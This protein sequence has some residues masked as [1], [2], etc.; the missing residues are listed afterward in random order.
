MRQAAD[1]PVCV[2]SRIALPIRTFLPEKYV[3]NRWSL[4]LLLCWLAL[5]STAWPSEEKDKG[6]TA[7]PRGKSDRPK[8]NGRHPTVTV[9]TEAPGL[10]PEEVEQLVTVPLETML[11]GTAGLRHVRSAS[12]AGRSVI[13]VEFGHGTDVLK[14][15][16]TVAERV[17]RVRDLPWGIH[18]ALVPAAA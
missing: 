13:W 11:G 1:V 18:P 15:R 4:S 10:A 16:Q 3:M 14:G 17:R 7:P 8:V 12:G 2:S 5:T 6:T 9:V